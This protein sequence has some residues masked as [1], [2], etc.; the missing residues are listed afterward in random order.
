MFEH[1]AHAQAGKT[2][3]SFS[4]KPDRRGGFFPRYSA[5]QSQDPRPQQILKYTGIRG[6]DRPKRV[7]FVAPKWRMKID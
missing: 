3:M 2:G 5:R 7:L 6:F 4:K 1:D